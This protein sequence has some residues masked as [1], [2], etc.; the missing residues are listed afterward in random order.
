MYTPPEWFPTTMNGP[1]AGTR[2]QPSTIPIR[3]SRRDV[4]GPGQ[5]W[6]DRYRFPVPVAP[7][8]SAA[9]LAE[10]MRVYQG[11]LVEH[12]DYLNALNVYPVPDADTGANLCS[13]LGGVVDALGRDARTADDMR[14]VCASIRQGAML[15]ARG[16]SGVITSQLLGAMCR[17]FEQHT[18][19]DGSL[20]TSGLASATDA[21]YRAVLH[22]K[23]GTILTVLRHAAEA[24]MVDGPDEPLEAVLDDARAAAG[25]ALDSTPDLLPALA[26]AGVVDSGGA[27]FLLLL[28]A[29]LHVAAGRPLPAAPEATDAPITAAIPD[30]MPRFEVVAKLSAPASAMEDF[31]AVWGGLGNESTVVV[32]AQGDWV[33]HVHTNL[34]DAAVETARAAGQIHD[35]LITDLV[36]QITELRARHSDGVAVVAV[37]SGHGVQER[38][39]K[40]GATCVLAGGPSLNPSAAEI[41]QAID[42]IGA[43]TVVL[44][45]NDEN[46]VPVCDQVVELSDRRILVVPTLSIPAGF[47]A[48]LQFDP[49][50]TDG[51]VER[52]RAAARSVVSGDVTRAVR[53]ARSPL[54]HIAAGDWIVRAPQV[55]RVTDD[56]TE[57]VVALLDHLVRDATPTHIEL[58]TGDG[59]S[60]GATD[61]ARRHVAS[62]WSGAEL[63]VSDG[64]QPH[65]AYLAGVDVA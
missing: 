1:S 62:R 52:M 51:A 55:V 43:Q 9:D 13:T 29:F 5:A 11:L 54:G 7:A 61:G 53:D 25:T 19:I 32:E 27:G 23:E 31:R 59:A 4:P 36:E 35:L 8:L 48:L 64:G 41:L 20:L 56:L 24:A 65:F 15:G 37:A 33:C 12:R 63:V 40:I 26:A 47:A 6:H 50:R 2:S 60:P 17:V 3:T 57:A 58:I 44:L 18:L 21:A 10:T 39:L 46:I 16:A 14:E 49:G 30:D 22:P 38:M 34:P 42:A 28:D 45:P